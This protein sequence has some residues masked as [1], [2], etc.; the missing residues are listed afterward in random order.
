MEQAL[1]KSGIRNIQLYELAIRAD[2]PEYGMTASGMILVN[3]PW[4]L[5]KTMEETLPWLVDH[6]GGE[7]AK[8]RLEQLV[9][10]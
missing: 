5:W 3:P 7:G 6:L 8:Y 9:S 1:K 4:A 10:E 2:N